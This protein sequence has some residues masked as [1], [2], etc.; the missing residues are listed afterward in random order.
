MS[1]TWDDPAMGWDGTWSWDGTEVPDP[2]PMLA[3]L[4]SA[5]FRV[6]ALAAAGVRQGFTSGVATGGGLTSSVEA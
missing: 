2:A 5:G 3:S 4:D 6:G 1:V